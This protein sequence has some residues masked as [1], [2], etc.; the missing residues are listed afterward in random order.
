MRRGLSAFYSASR[1]GPWRAGDKRRGIFG[2]CNSARPR[3]LFPGS[4]PHFACKPPLGAKAPILSRRYLAVG[5]SAC[6]PPR[7]RQGAPS[8]NETASFVPMSVNAKNSSQ[9]KKRP[10]TCT[11]CNLRF[12]HDESSAFARQ[13]AKKPR[14]VAIKSNYGELTAEA[15]DL[16]AVRPIQRQVRVVNPSP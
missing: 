1:A 10:V 3:G 7:W 14:P 2:L 8:R 6:S 16:D 5:V 9:A 4:T 11:M 12:R 13:Q 15:G